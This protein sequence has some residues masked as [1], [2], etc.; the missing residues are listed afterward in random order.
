MADE[1]QQALQ[2]RSALIERRVADLIQRARSAHEQWLAA[3]DPEP[4]GIGAR[5]T[6]QAAGR[7]TAAYRD[8]HGITGRAPLG[9]DPVPP[10]HRPSTLHAQPQCYLERPRAKLRLPCG[11]REHNPS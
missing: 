1:Y 7:M 5:H 11:Q 8:R 6:R 9:S 10:T 3:V 4:G 2:G